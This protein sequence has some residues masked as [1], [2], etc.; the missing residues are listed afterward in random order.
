MSVSSTEDD[1]VD[2]VIEVLEGYSWTNTT[3]EVWRQS[4]QDQQ[5]RENNPDPAIYV[6]SPVDA[7]LSALGAK[8]E[9]TDESWTVECSIWILS[10]AS[11]DAYNICK[12][13]QSDL[14]DILEDYV[15]DNYENLNFYNVRPQSVTDSR[16]ES[17][18]SRTDHLVMGVQAELNNLRDSGT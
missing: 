1:P 3:P 6:W 15:T 9:K 18:A 16:Q 12:Q 13:Y 4:E 11:T 17:I 10:D 8:R 7:D 5:Y 2:A 14:V